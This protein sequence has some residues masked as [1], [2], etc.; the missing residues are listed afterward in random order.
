MFL[1][2][3]K[4]FVRM[5]NEWDEIKNKDLWIEKVIVNV[6]EKTDSLIKTQKIKSISNFYINYQILLS[7]EIK[8]DIKKSDIDALNSIIEDSDNLKREI[9]KE[10]DVYL[11][12]WYKDDI[13]DIISRKKELLKS[14]SGIEEWLNALIE[15]INTRIKFINSK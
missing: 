14:N 2:W 11:L 8:Q 4:K 9:E 5:T 15:G 10:N 12:E 1:D 3:L 13:L 7:E 6:W